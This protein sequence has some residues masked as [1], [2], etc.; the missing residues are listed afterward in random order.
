M[1]L[2][3]LG[4]GDEFLIQNVYT[5]GFEKLHKKQST[6]ATGANAKGQTKVTV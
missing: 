1:M 3:Y 4:Q 2:Q 6:S 5:L